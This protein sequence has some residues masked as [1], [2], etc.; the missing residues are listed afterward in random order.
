MSSRQQDRRGFTLIELLVVIS[1]IA[2]LVAV[3]LPAL[4]AA[5]SAART[6]QCLANQ[7]QLFLLLQFYMADW[8]EGVPFHRVS[9]G[10]HITGFSR[11]VS[12]GYIKPLNVV[13][14]KLSNYSGGG[15]VRF[16]SEIPI[17]VICGNNVIGN[18]YTHFMMAGEV[19]GYSTDG[20]N[21]LWNRTP[22][23]QQ[24][25]IKPTG[26]MAF[27]DSWYD[28]ATDRLDDLFANLNEDTDPAYRVK[29]GFNE[30]KSVN[31]SATFASSRATWRHQRQNSNF[32]FFDGH[33]QTR[34]RL[35]FDVYTRP[36]YTSGPSTIWA[37]GFGYV[38]GPMRGKR[39][40][41]R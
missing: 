36:P 27:S 20:V 29:P 38:L 22:I 35:T 9:G 39:Y 40:D 7:R 24:D 12:K 33:G 1:V 16:C 28:P 18:G 11:V 31:S 5:R 30:A 41:G 8:K 37:G 15:D 21:W 10:N 34:M 19:T 6:T 26:T 25:I 23:R 14:G 3:L 17:T 13:G 32:V 2:L 4:A